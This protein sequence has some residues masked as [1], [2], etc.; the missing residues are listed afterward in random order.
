MILFEKV[1]WKNF[2]STG[3]QETEIVFTEKA[4]NIVIGTNGAGKS[5]VLDALCFSLFGKP[6]RKINK[7]QLVNSVNEKDCRVEV[8][9]S[10]GN[11]EWK[12]IRGIK[13]NVFEI[14]RDGNPL[15]QSAAALDQQKW[16]E[17]N[18]LKMN[19]K[20]FTQIVILGSSTFV[21]F[22]QLTAANR[23]EVIEDLLDI[24]IFS[25]M[26]TI[27]KD[28]IRT[29]KEDVKVL[30][31]KKESL[32]DKVQMQENFIEELENRGKKNIEDKE[33]KIGE[34][35]VEENTW[36]GDNEEK[37]KELIDLQGKLEDYTGATEKLRTLG[38]L[39]GKISNKVS[40]ITKEH[41]FFTQNTVCPTCDQAIEETFR[42]NRINDAQTK[43]KELQSGY[44]ELEE[45]IK[46]EEERERQFLTLSKEITSLTHGIS[47]NNTQIAGC[48]RQIR[49]L[50]SEIQ[51]IA[52]N[53][54]NRNIE[55]E[56]LTTFKDNLKTTYDEIAQRKDTI[57]YY[58][59]SYSL[60]KDGGVKTKIIKKYLPLIN[61]QV[62]KYLQLMD[63]YI[64]FSLDEEFNETV[65]SP[66]HENFSYSSFSEGE[67]MR[68]DLAL[69]F[70]WREVARMKNS[71]NTNLLIMDEVFDSSLDGLGT[72]DF[73]KIVRF[74]IKDANIFVISHKESLHDKFDNV[75]R[76]EKVKG[77]SRVVS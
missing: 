66:I 71:V 51:R 7:P 18:V 37:N 42:I 61:Q 33:S 3:N 45:A 55:H 54:A 49:D 29:L 20:S 41:K 48:Q 16:L 70:T 5:T 19:Y 56:K 65:Q 10:I 38:N 44:K 46:K 62:N 50:E 75:L 25:S 9:F 52:D 67:K 39:K 59:F 72:E 13:P 47:K 8:E 27:I 2:L 28:K 43:A 74:V 35:L 36:M 31:L 24:R 1:R 23:R 11:T 15:N 40:T 12:I 68:I 17:Q 77:F 26:N 69:L 63:F 73:L 32:G 53:L 60:L 14:Y 58:D 57:N 6:F 22:M 76:F 4:T 34:L 64:N 21:P 30:E